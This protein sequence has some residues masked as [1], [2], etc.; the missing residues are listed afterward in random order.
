MKKLI[1]MLISIISIYSA[2]AQKYTD[3]YIKDASIVAESWLSNINNNQYDNAFKMLSNEVKV[4]YK[5]KTW[6]NLINE[7]MLEFG[8]LESRK[9]TEKK[10]QSEVEGMEDGFYVLIE[11]TSSYTNTIDHNEH[12][13][14]KQNDK[15]KWE[16]VDYNYEFKNKEK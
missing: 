10:F 16:I 4:R 8:E 11:Y 15:I 14:L 9:T 6:I 13:L 3:Q 1:I 5:Q 12:I 7:L 2:S